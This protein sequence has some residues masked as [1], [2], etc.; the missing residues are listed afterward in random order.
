MDNP[1]KTKGAV[2][3]NSPDTQTCY[4]HCTNLSTT[5]TTNLKQDMISLIT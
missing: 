2:K 4:Q 3:N 1:G 5:T